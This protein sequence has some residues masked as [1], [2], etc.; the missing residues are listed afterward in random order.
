VLISKLFQASLLYFTM[1]IWAKSAVGCGPQW[2]FNC[3]SSYSNLL[4]SALI[5]SWHATALAVYL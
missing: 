2:T 4:V 3:R 1:P 5:C